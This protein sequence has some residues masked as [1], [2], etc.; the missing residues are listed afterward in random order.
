MLG[1]STLLPALALVLVTSS[2]NENAVAYAA[3]D[4]YSMKPDQRVHRLDVEGSGGTRDSVQVREESSSR[5][6][7]R[8]HL[9]LQESGHLESLRDQPWDLFEAWMKAYEKKYEKT[10]DMMMRFTVFQENA[11]RIA[12]HNLGASNTF[13][14]ALN[15]FADMTFEEFES[16]SLGYKPSASSSGKMSSRRNSKPSEFRYAHSDAPSSMD[17]RAHGAVTPV[18]NQ[19]A[20]GSCWAFSTTGAI[21]GI[22]KIQTGS[23]VSLSE[24][25]L[26]DCDTEVDMGCNGGLM[27]DAFTY[28]VSNG[29]I[30]TEADYGYWAWGLP[31]QTRR[32][33][34]RP[35]VTI[36]GYEDVPVNSRDALK[37]AIANQ[38]VAVAICANSALQFYHSGVMTDAACCQDLN[39]GVLAVGYEDGDDVENGESHWIVK[40]S[41]GVE[42]GDKGYFKLAQAS[43]QPAGACGI[44]QAASYPVKE[45]HSNPQVPDVCGIFGFTECAIGESCQCDFNLFGLFCLMW[46]CV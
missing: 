11:A 43:S 40:N 39:H 10:E 38:P 15:Q 22:N 3:I 19:G 5:T 18:K 32:E 23:L 42:W 20:C 14:M 36:D 25:Q 7:P 4:E 45:G 30:D 9:L 37:K 1:V 6:I 41:W 28:V 21:E 26:V 13:L 2:S 31:C 27:D 44:Y 46:E 29:G 35:V 33:H 8:S 12:E 24:Q 34:D 16:V 17:W